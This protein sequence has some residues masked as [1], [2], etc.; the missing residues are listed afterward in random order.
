MGLIERKEQ[1]VRQIIRLRRAERSAPGNRDIVA[2]RAELER[3]LGE[4]VAQ[5]LAARVLGIS[6]TALQRWIESGELATVYTERGKQ[7]IPVVA[8]FD[9]YE[10]VEAQ[11]RSGA[12]ARHVLE[13]SILEGR[14]RARRLHRRDLI[15]DRHDSTKV[16][17][18]GL[19][20]LRSLAYHRALARRLRR[21]MVDEA[22]HLVWR[23]RD[24]GK[25]DSRYAE[26]WESILSRP[27]RQI[28]RAITADTPEARD[29][30]QNSP[31]AGLL[32]EAERRKILQEIR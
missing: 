1:L 18:H 24:E 6:H 11:R 10:A 9:L 22:R 26:Q 25:M 17:G 3:E 21:P 5:R 32:S 16:A 4:T 14:E 15:R 19:A 28:A 23:W 7:E 12:R 27:V 29:L 30:R 13:P 20:D 8:L 2:V 31:F